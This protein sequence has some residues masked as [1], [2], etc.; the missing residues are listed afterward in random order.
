MSKVVKIKS[1]AA[2]YVIP[3][4]RPEMVESISEIGRHQRLLDKIN[5][6]MNDELAK[7]KQRYEES[8]EPHS[9]AISDLS[10]GVQAYCEAHR[11]ELTDHGKTK[12]IG[13]PSGEVKWRAC[14]P[15]VKIYGAD[16]VIKMLQ[17]K[18][19]F[20]FIREKI[21]INKEAILAD[22]KAV[23]GIKGI[24][25]VDDKEEFVIEP[26]ESKLEAVA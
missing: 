24:T 17:K 25:I 9:K 20:G 7:I 8:A 21:E 15:S 3:Q 1:Q 14:P 10:K 18:G 19:M 23:I 2:T 13:L 26:F 12:T 16:A 5:A 6:E 11:D 4:S 22:P